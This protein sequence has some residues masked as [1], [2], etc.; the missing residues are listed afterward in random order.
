MLA[1]IS[2]RPDL[3]TAAPRRHDLEEAAIETLFFVDLNTAPVA[4]ERNERDL[5]EELTGFYYTG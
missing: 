1:P 2:E 5:P 4:A 3:D